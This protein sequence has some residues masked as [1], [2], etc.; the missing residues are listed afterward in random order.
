LLFLIEFFFILTFNIEFIVNWALYIFFLHLMKLSRSYDLLCNFGKLTRV[1]SFFLIGLFFFYFLCDYLN[2]MTR[3]TG[4]SGWP[5][6]FFW[7]F[8]YRFVFQFHPSI[9]QSYFFFNF[10]FSILICLR[11][12]FYNL[13][14][15]VFLELSLDF[16]I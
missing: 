15:F 8:F 14:Q 6:L 3:I 5:S 1:N 12:E 10:I 2:L 13:C 11:I 16:N 4:L 9:T 7:I